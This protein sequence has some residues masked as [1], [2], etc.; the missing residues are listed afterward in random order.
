M[1]H[2]KP[3]MVSHL[4]VFHGSHAAIGFKD[5]ARPAFHL[6]G[7]VIPKQGLLRLQSEVLRLKFSFASTIM[8]CKLHLH[9][10]S[11][12]QATFSMHWMIHEVA[13]IQY[14]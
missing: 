10:Q 8:Y 2:W 6:V 9:N 1:K 11:L 5:A 4:E 7:G 3:Q 14:C 12:L 13:T